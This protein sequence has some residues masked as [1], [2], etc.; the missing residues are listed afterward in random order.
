ME[1]EVDI[2]INSVNFQNKLF[3]TLTYAV[4]KYVEFTSLSSTKGGLSD[5]PDSAERAFLILTFCSAKRTSLTVL[6]RK[7]TKRISFLL[8][9]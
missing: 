3:G 1:H 4:L 6:K 2:I 7:K 9:V 5:F 8:P